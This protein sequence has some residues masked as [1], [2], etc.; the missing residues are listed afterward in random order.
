M[1]IAVSK[2]DDYRIIQRSTTSGDAPGATTVYGKGWGEV[3]LSINSDATNAL[4]YRIRDAQS[5]TRIIQDW[6]STDQSSVIGQSILHL[7]IGA[8]TD[9]Y[10]VDV[11][12]S[13]DTSSYSSSTPFFVGN[14]DAAA[15]QSK[16]SAFFGSYA[17][18]TDYAAAQPSLYGVSAPF[19]TR[20]LSDTNGNPFDSTLMTWQQPGDFDIAGGGAVSTFPAVYL[21]LREQELGVACGLV[22]LAKPGA[23][24]TQ[25]TPGQNYWYELQAL[26]QREGNHVSTFIWNQGDTDWSTAGASA[27]QAEFQSF[28]DSLDD[29][30][31]RSFHLVS[32]DYM[33][34]YGMQPDRF[35]TQV[36]LAKAAVSDAHGGSFV[37]GV[38][39][40]AD[41]FGGHPTML[42][43][44]LGAQDLFRQVLAI[45]NPSIDQ[46][47]A[48]T[49]LGSLVGDTINLQVQQNLGTALVGQ[50]TTFGSTS[51]S[52]DAASNTDLVSQFSAFE[53]GY[54]DAS[55]ELT[56]AAVDLVSATD[57]RLTLAT[58]TS[59]SVD[60]WYRA[61][62]GTPGNPNAAIRDDVMDYGIPYGHQLKTR[63]TAIEVTDGKVIPATNPPNSVPT[64]PIPSAPV[65]IPSLP[66]SPISTQNPS[67]TSPSTTV[68]PSSPVESTPTDP[69]APMSTILDVTPQ[70]PT[71]SNAP[72]SGP[73][74]QI[75]P[76]ST[77]A[78]TAIYRF[79][80]TVSGAHIFT[81]DPNEF[82]ST[83][84][85][86]VREGGNFGSL[87][88]TALKTDQA[89]AQVYRLFD[90]STG[91]H[92]Y[93]SSQAELNGLTSASSS[94]YRPD[95]IFEPS[96]GFIEHTAQQTGDLAVYRFFDITTGGH[97]FT[98]SQS[99]Y[100][101]LT[102]SA[103]PSY[104]AD[105]HFED[106]AFYAP[107][108]NS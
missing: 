42:A 16:A 39:S 107:A 90:T 29:M 4:S 15:G 58:P 45:D 99:E 19:S 48:L 18:P 55:H 20:V 51:L 7:V 100:A 21:D 41:Y 56:I 106:I 76:A 86:F 28:V 40:G 67:S 94:T 74:P 77:S 38:S 3:D 101:G 2:M 85:T 80:E 44:I 88:D 59:G 68:L 57:I 71:A 92:F 9:C 103:G 24:V 50:I 91:G 31:G 83:N 66:S 30:L 49:G 11:A 13:L 62:Y 96:S 25:W 17:Y 22:G 108:V 37:E 5:P 27:Y 6:N 32:F 53:H 34:I 105:I 84:P 8:S 79:F 64:N 98:S 10:I 93:T 14:V 97:F 82:T 54:S 12:S 26:L 23:S 43:R 72:T 87:P 69:T 95:L 75:T 65:S 78:Q 104:R 73:T 52:I 70:P 46:G 33:W 36:D 63:L 35:V 1:T 102:N 60:V 81:Q 89:A 47:P 61:D